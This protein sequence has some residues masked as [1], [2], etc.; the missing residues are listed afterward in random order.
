MHLACRGGDVTVVSCLLRLGASPMAV[1]DQGRTPL[2]DACWTP[3]PNLEICALLLAADPAMA[4]LLDARGSS[5]CDY[6]RKEHRGAWCEFLAN[7]A[8]SPVLGLVEDD[9][10][11]PVPP[12]VVPQPVPLVSQHRAASHVRAPPPLFA[13]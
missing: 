4:T 10:A 11:T 3:E 1:D 8:G 7:L 13:V 5:P 12:S 6:V 2:H 9:A